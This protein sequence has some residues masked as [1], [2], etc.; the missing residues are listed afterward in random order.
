MTTPAGLLLGYAH[1][2]QQRPHLVADIISTVDRK[3]ATL[4]AL[5]GLDGWIEVMWRQPVGEP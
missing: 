2:A 5:R 1:D 4:D 3:D